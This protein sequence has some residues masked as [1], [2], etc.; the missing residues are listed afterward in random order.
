MKIPI[1]KSGEEGSKPSLPEDQGE[2][3]KQGW[4]SVRDAVSIHGQLGKSYGA[5]VSGFVQLSEDVFTC[6]GYQ[7]SSADPFL[8]ILDTTLAALHIDEG[9][10]YGENLKVLLNGNLLSKEMY[11]TIMTKD[12]FPLSIFKGEWEYIE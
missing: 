4:V 7:F 2:S 5:A 1:F 12:L 3:T 9:L 6:V 11:S 8:V 10:F